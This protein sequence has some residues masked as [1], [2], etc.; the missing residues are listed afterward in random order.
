MSA[1]NP[2]EETV[3]RGVSL[4]RPFT[5][6]RSGPTIVTAAGPGCAQPLLQ[7]D[8]CTT[9]EVPTNIRAACA[10]SGANCR[11]GNFAAAHAG[12]PAQAT[13]WRRASLASTINPCS[14]VDSQSLSADSC[15]RPMAI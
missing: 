13:T 12:V 11:V 2:A 5:T 10:T 9:F 6:T 4:A 8:R 7:P 14:A 3:A 15:D 1:I